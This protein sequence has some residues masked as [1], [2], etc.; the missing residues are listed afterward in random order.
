MDCNHSLH[1]LLEAES[2]LLCI[3]VGEHVLLDAQL[4]HRQKFL[5]HLGDILLQQPG[6]L[7]NVHRYGEQG[8]QTKNNLSFRHCSGNKVG[9][10]L[11]V[12]RQHIPS[13]RVKE[14]MKKQ[15]CDKCNPCPHEE[16]HSHTLPPLEVATTTAATKTP[17][18]PMK[19]GH[20]HTAATMDKK[21]HQDWH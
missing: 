18:R 17:T 14:L 4:P 9:H 1:I 3:H 10:P 8:S 16:P 15:I 12:L 6:T 11:L 13:C 21:E 2:K 19:Q 5:L 20:C 7:I